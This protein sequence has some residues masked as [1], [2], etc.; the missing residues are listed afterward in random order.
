M[1]KCDWF[2]IKSAGRLRSKDLNSHDRLAT[3]HQPSLRKETKKGEAN[4]GTKDREGERKIFARVD[5][6]VY[7]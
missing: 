3:T 5:K 2:L 1:L 6:S 4:A 7:P